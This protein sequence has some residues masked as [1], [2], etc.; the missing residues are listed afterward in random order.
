[1]LR[2]WDLMVARLD[3]LLPRRQRPTIVRLMRES[4]QVLGAFVR[5]QLLVMVALGVIYGAGLAL[6]GLSVGPLIGMVAGL[7]SF[8][9]YLGFI[10][11]LVAALIAVMVQYGDWLHLGLLAKIGRASCRERGLVILL[12]VVVR[13]MCSR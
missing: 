12:R 5:G 9:P 8:V 6:I 2:D 10:I 4:D 11:G 1:L 7:L 3:A 13:V